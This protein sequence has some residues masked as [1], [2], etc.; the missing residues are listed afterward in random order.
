MDADSVLLR[1]DGLVSTWQNRVVLDRITFDFP[2]GQMLAIIGPNGGGKTTL[3]RTLA[4]LHRPAQGAVFFHGRKM[5][6]PDIRIGYVPQNSSFN[7]DFPATVA[8]VIQTG[9]HTSL[10]PIGKTSRKVNSTKTDQIIALL[11]L[12][13]IMDTTIDRLSGGQLQRVLIAR[14]L[15]TDPDLLLMD[16]PLANLDTEVSHRLM[17][18][19]HEHRQTTAVIMS[20]HNVE[21]LSRYF[22]S[23][24]CLNRQLHYHGKMQ[25]EQSVFEEVYGCDV[26]LIAHGLPHRV[27]AS[28]RH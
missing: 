15:M 6:R 21:V 18:F 14:A 24:A 20:T 8:K 2:G 25:L 5:K 1:A 22:D 13:K 16:E 4:G 9:L 23:L 26:E 11:A 7:P 17:Q 3:L 10:S 27:V 12:E 19:L 28:H